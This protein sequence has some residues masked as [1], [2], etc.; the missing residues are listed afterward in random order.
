MKAYME[1]TA[2]DLMRAEQYWDE[3]KSRVKRLATKLGHEDFEPS[4][5]FLFELFD[6]GDAVLTDEQVLEE[7]AEDFAED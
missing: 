1:P 2:E 4:D 6:Y 5:E 7:L 3:Q